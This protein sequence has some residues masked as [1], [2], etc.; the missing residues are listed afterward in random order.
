[1]IILLEKYQKF[2]SVLSHPNDYFEQYSIA[3]NPIFGNDAFY[4]RS[5]LNSEY[6]LDI[7]TFNEFKKELKEIILK[8]K[9]I[10]GYLTSIEKILIEENKKLDDEYFNLNKSST[11][12]QSFLEMFTMPD[13]YNHV[14]DFKI[15]YQ[16]NISR[17]N[18]SFIKTKDSLKPLSF[19]LEYV[20]N[21]SFFITFD[22][23]YEI[24]DIYLDFYKDI[25]YSIFGIKENG[26]MENIYENVSSTEKLFINTNET[27]YKKI[28]VTGIQ[29]LNGLIKE[30]KVFSYAKDEILEKNGYL[31]Y[32]LENM[33]IIKEYIIV[34]DDS[35]ELYG[36]DKKTYYKMIELLASNEKLCIEKYFNKQYKLEK[37]VN[38]ENQ[39]TDSLYI[40]ELFSVT[41][42][43]S[44]EL[45]FFAKEITL[46]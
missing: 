7:S 16:K 8:Y 19:Y 37:N 5:Y 39:S 38:I 9:Y 1:M 25:T 32:L 10:L 18:N 35:T 13:Y 43:K 41:Q 31:V 28:F 45:K 22:K 2:K 17:L 12:G 33:N 4:T 27:K 24:Q 14:L 36:F 23:P 46:T 34:S 20:K 44:N 30:I 15:I 11:K 42:N 29:N 21:N 40:L 26:S 6:Q 3:D